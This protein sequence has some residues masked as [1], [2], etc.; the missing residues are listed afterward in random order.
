MGTGQ[1]TLRDILHWTRACHRSLSISLH[2]FADAGVT[3]SLKVFL[4]DL[5]SHESIIS[6]AI[7]HLERQENP[8]VLAGG[9]EEYLQRE[10]M[11]RSV[12]ASGTFQGMTSWE[13][14]GT[15]MEQHKRLIERCRHLLD[16][17]RASDSR[18]LLQTLCL[19]EEREAMLMAQEVRGLQDF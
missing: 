1:L 4:D 17:A 8:W 9:C 13:I 3:L 15:V 14:M 19:L 6:R 10:R 7:D 16:N 18:A 5:A 11:P 2:R 12:A